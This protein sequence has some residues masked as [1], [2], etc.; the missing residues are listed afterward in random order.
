M[1]RIRAHRR[2]RRRC[3]SIERPA[4][5]RRGRRDRV[6][7][8]GH[9]ETVFPTERAPGFNYHTFPHISPSEI[10]ARDYTNS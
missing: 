9:W 10:Q 8:N 3:S 4:V 7:L 1:L 2:R 6:L 5:T